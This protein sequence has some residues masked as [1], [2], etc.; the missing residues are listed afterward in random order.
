MRVADMTDSAPV[1]L[2]LWSNNAELVPFVGG[3][4][5]IEEENLAISEALTDDKSLFA[6]AS[7]PDR[8][9]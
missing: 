9:A 5:R 3:P 7:V 2:W 4:A 6:I 1:D 8:A